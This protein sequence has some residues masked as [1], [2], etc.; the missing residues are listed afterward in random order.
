MTKNG[1]FAVCHTK[2]METLSRNF[3]GWGSYCIHLAALPL[4]FIFFMLVFNPE[5]ADGEDFGSLFG[6]HYT[7]NLIL[8]ATIILACESLVRLVFTFLCHYPGFRVNSFNYIL[9]CLME[10]VIIALFLGLYTALILDRPYLNSFLLCLRMDLT[11]L[12]FPYLII[13]LM[14]RSHAL[15]EALT[16]PSEPEH[17][18]RF[19]DSGKRLRLNIAASA[20]LYLE[21]DENYV[22]IYYLESGQIK[23]FVLRASMKSL[24]KMSSDNGLRRC[25]RRYLIN[26][27]HVRVLRKESEGVIFAE[28]DVP[29]AETIPISR[30]YYDGISELL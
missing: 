23:T 24:E 13:A 4:F 27:S 14:L 20:V 30:R 28:L 25:H 3:K 22:N 5:L 2:D 16:Q 8:L 6:G 1:S 19:Y 18:M 11:V 17:L 9:W 21:S 7:M 29:G 15:S 26:P 10:L 12:C